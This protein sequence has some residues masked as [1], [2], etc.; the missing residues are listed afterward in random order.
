MAADYVIRRF[1]PGDADGVRA[2]VERVYGDS[3]VHRELYHPEQLVRVHETGQQASIVT[4]HPACGVVGHYAIERFDLGIIAESGEGAVLDPFMGSG[5]TLV[6]AK[7]L[8]R[9]AIGIEIE[10][11][12]CEIAV[13]RLRQG[14]LFGAEAG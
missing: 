8:G 6:A 4:V 2:L 5:T 14:V 1:E 10:E 9:K 3:Y 7:A 13:E 12:Y 11:R